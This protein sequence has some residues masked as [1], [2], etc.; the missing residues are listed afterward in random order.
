MD[1][2]A[3][4]SVDGLGGDLAPQAV[5]DGVRRALERDDALEVLL[6]GPADALSPFAGPRLKVHAT[7]EAIT[8]GE[9]PVQA[10]RT[11]KD[12]SLVV[13]ARLV[14]DGQADG[15]FSAGS[16]GACLAAGTLIVG[17][18]PGVLRPAIAV[19]LPGKKP[20]VFLDT[21]ANADV[22]PAYLFQYAQMGAAYA[23]A[24]L[25][26]EAPRL[27]L[28]NIGEED[29]KGNKLAQEAFE[30]MGDKLPDFI[31][32]VEG[33]DLL[34]GVADVI[35]TDGFTGNVT[36]KTL[37]GSSSYILGALRDALMASTI[38]KLGALALKRQLSGLKARLDPDTYGG[39]PLLGAAGLVCIGHGSSSAE[40]VCSGILVAAKAVRAG[41]VARIASQVSSS[42]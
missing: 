18:I 15:F 16:T 41:L 12:S 2:T 37:E 25:D 6:T 38:S 32:N 29:S 9:H 13:A 39:A 31:G 34:A 10:V 7:T 11:R 23:R 30:L 19:V 8:M 3:R 22:K 35:V 28:L 42:S 5:I 27:A 4:I 21:G 24:I 17:R 33:R 20:T 36:L 26:L 14:K 40:A 1:I